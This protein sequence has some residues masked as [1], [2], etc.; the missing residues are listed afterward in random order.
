M[1]KNADIIKRKLNS[2]SSIFIVSFK[3]VSGIYG[4]LFMLFTLDEYL[5]IRAYSAIIAIP[6]MTALGTLS[7]V[8]T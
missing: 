4:I 2:L 6:I 5:N 1:N 8:L 3:I 7:F